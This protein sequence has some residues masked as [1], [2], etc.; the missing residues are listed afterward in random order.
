MSRRH[1]GGA[2]RSPCPSLSPRHDPGQQLPDAAAHRAVADTPCCARAGIPRRRPPPPDSG[3]PRD[4]DDLRLVPSSTV[5]FS[6]GAIV[7]FSPGVDN[8]ASTDNLHEINTSSDRIM[9]TDGAVPSPSGDTELWFSTAV[10]V[11][12][13]PGQ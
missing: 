11:G 1:G 13:G 2:H 7:R 4:D 10:A 9:G 5:R 3:S 6:P 8:R 12:G